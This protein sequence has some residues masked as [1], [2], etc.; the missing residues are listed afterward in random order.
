MEKHVSQVT[1]LVAMIFI[2]E[3]QT[4]WTIAISTSIAKNCKRSKQALEGANSLPRF[5]NVTIEPPIKFNRWLKNPIDG[6]IC[7]LSD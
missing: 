5:S 6:H 7:E 1:N 2:F 3:N 4:L